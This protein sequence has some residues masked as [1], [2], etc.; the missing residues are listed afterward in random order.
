MQEIATGV[1]ETDK[2]IGAIAIA[3]EQQQATVADVDESVGE[4]NKRI[5]QSN[6]TRGG[7]DH[8][9]HARSV[10]A[11]GARPHP[12]STSSRRSQANRR[13]RRAF[14]CKFS[15][16]P[17]LRGKV[18]RRAGRGSCDRYSGPWA[19]TDTKTPLPAL[20]ATFPRETGEGMNSATTWHMR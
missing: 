14:A 13:D 5:G 8:R 3:M 15:A 19:D 17:R 11:G 7:G 12:R 1:A 2:L 20:R 9:H 6:A 10:A 16:F 4:L 18:A